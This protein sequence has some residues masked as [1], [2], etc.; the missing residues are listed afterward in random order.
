MPA[1]V[2][3]DVSKVIAIAATT[4]MAKILDVSLVVI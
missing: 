1:V 3:V 2:V 4:T